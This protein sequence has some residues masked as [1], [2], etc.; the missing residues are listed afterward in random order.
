MELE[1]MVQVPELAPVQANLDDV[2]A[3]VRSVLATV[4]GLVYD[5]DQLKIAKQDRAM[6]NRLKKSL[7]DAR[8]KTERTYMAPAKAFKADVDAIIAQISDAISGIDAQLQAAED[9]RKDMKKGHLHSM[10]E[11][12]EFPDWVDFEQIFD[13]RWLNATAKIPQIQ[14]EME[15]RKVRILYEIQSCNT[16]PYPDEAIEAYKRTLD[17]GQAI[18]RSTELVEAAKV[19]QKQPE[20]APD[21]VPVQ[22]PVEPEPENEQREWV[23]FDAYLSKAEA[24]NLG[25]WLRTNQIT[26]RRHKEA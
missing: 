1:L 3:Y 26:Y 25:R 10:F 6:L 18:K 7:N 11:Y 24:A 23:A 15:D 19:L 17:I 8:I 13:P 14:R 21:P 5:D 4:D 16:L 9:Y 20:P 22:G 2:A 12:L